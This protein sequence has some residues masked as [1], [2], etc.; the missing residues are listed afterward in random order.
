MS[1]ATDHDSKTHPTGP[2][3]GGP[4]GAEYVRL[5][6][7]ALAT[8][9]VIVGDGMLAVRDL[10]LLEAVAHKLE[11]PPTCTL[12]RDDGREVLFFRLP[13]GWAA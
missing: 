5:A 13:P 3:S 2:K 6:D 4:I 7:Q 8:G 9:T 11:I 12:L 1:G 10:V